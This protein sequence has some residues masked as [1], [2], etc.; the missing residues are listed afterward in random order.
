MQVPLHCPGDVVCEGTLAT[1][2]C[3]I[4]QQRTPRGARHVDGA[5]NDVFLVK[6][7]S[8]CRGTITRGGGLGDI[9]LRRQA[10]GWKP[11]IRLSHVVFPLFLPLRI[12][13]RAERH[14]SCA[15]ASSCKLN[16]G[17]TR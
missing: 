8:A 5:D 16:D 12:L 2:A 7:I 15:A 17:W 11:E 13:V 9:R 14:S 1:P 4:D 10:R 3:T 6:D